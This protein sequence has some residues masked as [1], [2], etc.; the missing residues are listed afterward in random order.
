MALKHR[1]LLKIQ[2]SNEQNVH[3]SLHYYY[4]SNEEHFSEICSTFTYWKVIIIL[5]S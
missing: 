2:Q 4:F 1:G 3:N 5:T